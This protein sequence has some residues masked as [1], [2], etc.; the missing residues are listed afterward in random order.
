MEMFNQPAI[1]AVDKKHG[2]KSHKTFFICVVPW[3]KS[4]FISKQCSTSV[5]RAVYGNL[6]NLVI[7]KIESVILHYFHKPASAD[8]STPI[9]KVPEV[10][11]K[12][13]FHL[14]PLLISENVIKFVK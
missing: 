2:F 11:G 8:I 14:F 7:L 13:V 4:Y 6:K 9:S 5:G 10:L 12:I 1:R 3:S